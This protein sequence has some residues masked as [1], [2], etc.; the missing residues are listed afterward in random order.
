MPNTG[1][2]GI[3]D[4]T[5]VPLT[6]SQ[7]DDRNNVGPRL[8]FSYNVYGTGKTILRGGYGMYFGRV[9]NANI[10]Q[11]YLESGSPNA[12]IS[13]SSLFTNNA[14]GPIFPTI[15]TSAAQVYDCERA[16]GKLPTS[17]IAYLDP[18]LQNPQVHEVDLALEQDLGWNT[19]FAVTYMGSFGREL[20]SSNDVNVID[21]G[22]T[23]VSYTVNNNTAASAPL[24]GTYITLPHG[25]KNPPLPNG[26]VYTTKLFVASGTTQPGTCAPSASRKNSCYGNILDIASNVNSSY[27]ALAVQLNRRFSQGFSFLTNYTWAHALDFNPYIGTGVPTFNVFDPTNLRK[28]YGNSSL[29]VRQ[30][31]V[32]AAVY[33]PTFNTHGWLKYAA[34]GWR[35]API[36]QAQTGLPYSPSV[37]GSAL[38]G[39]FKGINGSGSSANRIDILGRNQVNNP[40]QAVVDLRVGK[41]FTLP[42]ARLDRFRLELFAEA[43]N[44][45]NHQNITS[46]SHGAYSISTGSTNTLNFMQNY[47]T[48]LNSNSNTVYSQRQMQLAA[49]LHF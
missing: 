13:F 20:D 17:T 32:F 30:R 41:N 6:A 42:G 18:H 43:F 44:L 48:Y 33:Q 22:A 1:N 34:E 8:G 12:Q 16:I 15:Y 35:I 26:F 38:G 10:L 29:D 36:V 45:M 25:G 40:K 39:A 27:N 47:G 11:T 37:S 3:G 14:C 46:V 31:F 23:T 21:S 49:R 19:T 9:P 7:P 24:P 5:G 2:P 4:T 28:E